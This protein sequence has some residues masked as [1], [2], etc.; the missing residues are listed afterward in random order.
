[1]TTSQEGLRRRLVKN[2]VVLA[3][4]GLV[5]QVAM[6]LVEVVMARGLGAGAYG[7]FA[8]TYAFA[9]LGI[10]LFD[11]GTTWWTIQEGSRRPQDLPWLLGDSL[12]LKT[13]TFCIVYLAV[14]VV[15]YFVPI[16]SELRSFIS[17]FALYTLAL[18]L[19]DTLAAVYTARQEMHVNAVFQALSPVVILLVYLVA[20]T[21]G[22]SL[23]DAAIAFV[24]GAVLIGATWMVWTVRK[25]GI[26]ARFPRALGMVRNSYH[27]GFTGI[28]RQVFYKSDVVMLAF[29]AGAVEA[30]VYA[31]AVKF[32]DLFQKIPVLMNRVVSPALYAESYE[33]KT[34]HSYEMI[35]S[36]YARLLISIGAIA[37][38]V[39]FLA[40]NDLVLLLFGSEYADSTDVLQIL[41]L[42]MVLKCMMTVSEGVLSSL[43]RHTERWTS[44][45]AVVVLNIGLNFLLIPRFG[46]IG[47]ASANIISG[48]T[49]VALYVGLGF[50]RARVWK[51]MVWFGVPVA[52]GLV[53]GYIT[54]SLG[55]GA[56]AAVPVA[57]VA[58]LVLLL[59]SR[60]VAISELQ[61]IGS[62]VLSRKRGS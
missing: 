56:F 10:L 33:R 32:V 12:F 31:A 38:L 4:G 24:A 26:E 11:L 13:G 19:I 42:V 36:G 27:Y 57:V 47:A 41:A 21:D 58:F 3:L 8:T 50:G 52:I 46:S 37:A 34:S 30:G 54:H 22:V 23:I 40:A 59:G 60:L 5:A 55:L 35:L 61:A 49:L 17:I 28:L 29:L 16:S 48:F 14:L 62:S 18:A 45:A 43:D 9:L 25:V 7:I 39:T 1:M 15:M 53:V 20:A 6:I 44:L 51:A 2:G